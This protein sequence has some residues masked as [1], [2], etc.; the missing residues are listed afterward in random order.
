MWLLLVAALV[1]AYFFLWKKPAPSTPEAVN[2]IWK[3]V[4]VDYIGKFEDGVVF[5]TSLE[6]VAKESGLYVEGRTYGPLDFVVGWQ[7]MIPWFDK[8]VRDMKVGETKTVTLQPAEAYGEHNPALI[9]TLPRSQFQDA[10]IVP[11]VGNTYSWP[12]GSF[13]VIELSGD[14]VTI[15]ANSEMAG[16]VLVF[17]IT[18]VRIDEPQTTQ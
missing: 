2:N 17:T 7:G 18:M 10:D 16:K 1:A 11:E 9:T 12:S 14:V 8:A 3:K 4:Y 13:K 15:D 5:D 6:Q